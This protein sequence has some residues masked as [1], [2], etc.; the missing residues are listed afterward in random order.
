M[1]LEVE[2]KDDLV[3]FRFI[4]K[5][6]S[7]QMKKP[8]SDDDFALKSKYTNLC[9]FYFITRILSFKIL[10]YTSYVLCYIL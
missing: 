8:S 2:A 5:L 3:V 6:L 7:D 4:V 9:M 1:N 10:I